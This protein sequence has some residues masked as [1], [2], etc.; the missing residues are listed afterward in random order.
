MPESIEIKEHILP[1][2]D[3]DKTIEPSSIVL[4]WWG[5]P[6]NNQGIRYLGNLLEARQLSVQFAV[7]VDGTIYRLTPRENSWARHAKCANES[8]IGIEIEGYDAADLDANSL[9]FDSVVM[10]TQ[11]LKRKYRIADEF[12]V[13]SIDDDTIRFYGIASHKQVDTYCANANGKVDVHDEYLAR[14]ISAVS[15]QA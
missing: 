5:E 1:W 14:V 4:H 12:G 13:D 10:L 6:V 9:Q 2:V 15:E 3:K 7:L 11:Y 8:A